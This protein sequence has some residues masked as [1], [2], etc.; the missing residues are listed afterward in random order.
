VTPGSADAAISV[1][2]AGA[3][4][5]Y[6]RVTSSFSAFRTS[7]G[8]DVHDTS[9]G[10]SGD[11][12]TFH[13][14]ISAPAYDW[15]AHLDGS[16]GSL[17]SSGY[18]GPGVRAWSATGDSFVGVNGNQIVTVSTSSAMHRAVDFVPGTPVGTPAVSPYGNFVVSAVEPAGGGP[19]DLGVQEQY[20]PLDAATMTTGGALS[21]VLGLSALDPSEPEVAL[22]PG[23][24]LQTAGAAATV[25]LAFKGIV[26]GN[27]GTAKLYVD[28]ADG[29]SGTNP[30]PVAD[31]GALCTTDQLA[32]SP[33]HTR[34]AYLKAIGAGSDPCGQTELHVLTANGARYDTGA[35]D[36]V[37]ATSPAGA[38]FSSPTWQAS[39][40]SAVAA[41]IGGRDRVEVAVNASQASLPDH[42]AGVVVVAGS[43]AFADALAGTPLAARKGGPVLFSASATLDPRTKAEIARVLITSGG[44][45]Y[46]VGGPATLSPGIES[47]LQSAGYKVVRMGGANRFEVALNIAKEL[48]GAKGN[49]RNVFVAD[50]LNWPDALVSGPAATITQGA[51]VLSN[52]PTLTA[53][54]QAFLDQL[55]F[56]AP[57]DVAS[58]RGGVWA[59]G[60]NAIKATAGRAD[61]GALGG[62]NRFAVATNVAQTFFGGESVTGVADGRNWPDAVSGG[63]TMAR[64]YQPILL[65][66]GVNQPVDLLRRVDATQGSSDV[67]LAFG[68]VFSVSDDVL[69]AA[70]DA[71]GRQTAVYGPD[72]R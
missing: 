70:T 71:A 63:A 55:G 19:R 12:A 41:R 4:R 27:L 44:T 52:G 68:G 51:V 56:T 30:V 8:A 39:T 40:P 14:S 3:T 20:F 57:P 22:P 66:N 48:A 50:G 13:R 10:P 26:A 53:D 7:A 6:D 46:L 31:L 5:T 24:S 25:Y 43:T 33:S 18:G 11:V 29:G 9:W 23:G 69:F 1:T 34:I 15:V 2:V 54:T 16:S 21:G 38:P 32:F 17:V 37:I 36:Q 45:V 65:A 47:T 72:S 49:N 58:G 28:H 62:A 64:S 61:T 42:S 60:G 35:V 67:V 59:V